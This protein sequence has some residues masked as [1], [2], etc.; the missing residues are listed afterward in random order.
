MNKLS[1]IKNTSGYLAAIMVMI[2]DIKKT[3]NEVI[4]RDHLL[5]NRK[6]LIKLKESS[7]IGCFYSNETGC[8]TAQTETAVC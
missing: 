7:V 5:T 4:S 2:H 3:G 8:S 1:Q 6:Q